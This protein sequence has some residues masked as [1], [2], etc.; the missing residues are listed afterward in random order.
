MQK[1]EMPVPT[2]LFFTACGIG[3]LVSWELSL[4]L[5]ISIGGLI[6]FHM[7]AQ[8]LEQARELRSES[9]PYVWIALSRLSIAFALGAAVART[10]WDLFTSNF[11]NLIPS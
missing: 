10:A 2:T 11:L 9:K 6:V 7:A 4:L 1:P 3:S 5:M 8:A